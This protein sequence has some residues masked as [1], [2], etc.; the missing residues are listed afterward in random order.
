MKY[1]GYQRRNHER[2]ERERGLLQAAWLFSIV[3]LQQVD[4]SIFVE[5][6][7]NQDGAL[8]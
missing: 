2:L 5:I 8:F 6:I 7:Y 4:G 3:R 1:Y